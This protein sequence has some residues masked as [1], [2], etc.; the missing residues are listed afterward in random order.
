MKVKELI[1]KLQELDPEAECWTGTF[2]RQKIPTYGLLD[3]T[4]AGNFS[5]FLEDIMPTPGDIDERLI[6]GKND[7]D[8]IVYLGT[9]FGI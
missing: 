6:S 8:P 7:N 9:T 2:N 4:Y 1:A 3:Y 5:D